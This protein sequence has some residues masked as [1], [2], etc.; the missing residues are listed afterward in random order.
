MLLLRACNFSNIYSTINIQMM[1]GGLR[2]HNINSDNFAHKFYKLHAQNNPTT[3][4]NVLDFKKSH[5]INSHQKKDKN[6]NKSFNTKTLIWFSSEK[7]FPPEKT[8]INE[9]N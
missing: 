5:R 2:S 4:L 3:L 1:V 7:K 6:Q 9:S 8:S